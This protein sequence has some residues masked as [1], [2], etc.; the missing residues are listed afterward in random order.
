[1]LTLEQEDTFNALMIEGKEDEA[2][3]F[4]KKHSKENIQK[5]YD[6]RQNT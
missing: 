6:N 3:E 1:M 5:E 2:H 4:Y